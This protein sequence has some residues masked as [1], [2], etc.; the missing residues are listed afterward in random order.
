MIFVNSFIIW[1]FVIIFIGIMFGVLCI[2]F[3]NVVK[4]VN[5]ILGILFVICFIIVGFLVKNYL[6]IGEQI[7]YMIILDIFVLLS[8]EWNYNMVLKI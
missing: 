4:L 5:G 3:I 6:S 8:K 2:L 7:V 1:L